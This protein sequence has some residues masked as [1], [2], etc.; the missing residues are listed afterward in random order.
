MKKNSSNKKKVRIKQTCSFSCMTSRC[1]S[2]IHL[3]SKKQKTSH[4]QNIRKVIK[5]KTGLEQAKIQLSFV[6]VLVKSTIFSQECMNG[7]NFSGQ[8]KIS[9]VQMKQRKIFPVSKSVSYFKARGQASQKFDTQTQT[10][11]CCQRAMLHSWCECNPEPKK[12]SF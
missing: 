10:N 12:T 3:R 7:S 5:M 4:H 2:N 8:D 1:Q 6:L 9:S 11:H